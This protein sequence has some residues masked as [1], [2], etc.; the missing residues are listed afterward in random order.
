MKEVTTKFG[1]YLC[2]LLT[3]GCGANVTSLSSIITSPNCYWDVHDKNSADNGKTAYCYK[4]NTDGSCLYLFA[5]NKEG[6]RDEYDFGDNLPTTKTWKL[7]G[8]TSLYLLGI[9]R[10]IVSFSKD[11]ILLENRINKVRDTL[12]R[13]CK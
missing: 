4:F 11:T 5:P 13:N 1:F 9:E 7:Q 3:I 10:T 8:D 12:I 6:V 2:F